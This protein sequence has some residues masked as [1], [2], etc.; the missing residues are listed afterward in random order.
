MLYFTT[1]PP[2]MESINKITQNYQDKIL[3]IDYLNQTNLENLKTGIN[4][5]RETLVELRKLIRKKSYFSNQEDEIIF[6]KQIKPFIFGR[7]KYFIELHNFQLEWPKADIRKQKKYLRQALNKLENQKKKNLPFW[8]YVRHQ[9]TSLDS[10]YFLRSNSQLELNFDIS[11]YYLNPEFSTNYDNLMSQVV[12]FDLLTNYYKKLLSNIEN[13]QSTQTAELTDQ[14]ISTNLVWSGS[15]TDLI[16]LIYALHASRVFGNG[17]VEISKI[18]QV[19]EQILNIKLGS[20]YKIFSEIKARTNQQTKF[21][22]TLKYN[23]LKKI[24]LDES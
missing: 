7:L 6:F 23:L 17:Q 4:I 11:D 20:P 8:R 10:F 2:H 18:T 24:K 19:F 13:N 3:Q 22:D 21:I 9:Q 12:A 15:K 14:A 1:N 16:E 5:S